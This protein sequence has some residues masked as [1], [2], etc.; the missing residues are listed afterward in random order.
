MF[1]RSKLFLG[2]TASAALYALFGPAVSIRGGGEM[3]AI[4][5]NLARNGFFGNPF[6]PTLATGPSAVV[7]PF[8][9]AFIGFLT[10][11]L[12]DS[13]AWIVL[14]TAVLLVQGLHASL[15]PDVSRRFFG[16]SRPG[17][18][19]A[20][21]CIALPVYSWM[22]YWDAMYTATGLMAMCLASTSGIALDWP[23]YRFASFCGLCAGLLALA[24]PTSV[25][26]SVP[27]MLWVLAGRRVPVWKTA[28]SCVCFGA[29]LT[30]VIL[31]WCLRN[32]YEI[33][34]LS[35]RTNLGMTL[36]ATNND[37]AVPSLYG[38]LESGCYQTHHP[39]GSLA[40][41]Q[42]L[43]RMGEPAFDRYRIAAT[44]AWAQAHPRRFLHLT[45]ARVAEFW[46][47][48]ANYGLYA[49]CIW[50]VTALSIPGLW[51]L[52]RERAVRFTASVFLL[53]P[54]LYYVVASDYR[55]RYPILWLT[56]LPAGYAIHS[57]LP[58]IVRA[59]NRLLPV[60]IGGESVGTAVSNR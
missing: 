24:G 1:I 11:T 60:P 18:Y 7:P 20:L 56:L 41:A 3:V 32:Y 16:D 59:L 50:L 55:Y 47:P 44:A 31:P 23:W 49:G 43:Q 27:W 14:A 54:C 26:V 8:Y 33:G 38:E 35:L 30:I 4:G 22:P 39:A 52:R 29:V 2:G 12:G 36:F 9:P 53:Y 5:L 45:A 15:L 6:A 51:L 57:V 34:T 21:I 46:F 19:A 40:E 58:V 10:T 42:T 48:S 25:L 28:R 13:A 17:I 37:C